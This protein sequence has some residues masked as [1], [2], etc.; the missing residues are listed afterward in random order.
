MSLALVWNHLPWGLRDPF[1]QKMGDLPANNWGQPKVLSSSEEQDSDEKPP[2]PAVH[3]A[4]FLGQLS[5]DITV[6]FNS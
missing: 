3:N 6:T 1:N 2:P 5:K 4:V